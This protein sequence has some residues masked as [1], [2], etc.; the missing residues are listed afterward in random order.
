MNLYCNDHMNFNDGT[1]CS[2]M[3]PVT[4]LQIIT[5]VIFST[6]SV[7]GH[8]KGHDQGQGASPKVMVRVQGTPL[9]MPPGPDR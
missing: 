4:T 1:C 7:R 9:K 5:A 2:S 3:E 6:R 8:L